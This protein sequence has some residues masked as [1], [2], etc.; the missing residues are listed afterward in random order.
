MVAAGLTPLQ[1]IQCATQ[2]TARMLSIDGQTG[3]LQPGKSA[4]LIVLDADPAVDIANSE[5]INLIFHHGK[6]VDHE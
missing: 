5:K 4:D 3:T 1:A 6:R 2:G